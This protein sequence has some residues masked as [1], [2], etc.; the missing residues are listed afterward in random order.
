MADKELPETISGGP[1]GGQRLEKEREEAFDISGDV[2]RK[3]EDPFPANR[4][5]GESTS[6]EHSAPV[7]R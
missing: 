5:R 6:A 2:K 1:A 4:E 3:G 7:G